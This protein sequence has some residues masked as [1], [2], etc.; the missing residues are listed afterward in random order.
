MMGEGWS[1]MIMGRGCMIIKWGDFLI[2][3]QQ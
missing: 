3:T 2:L 1:G